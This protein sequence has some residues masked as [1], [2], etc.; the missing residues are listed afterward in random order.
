MD[1]IEKQF[2]SSWNGSLLWRRFIGF[3]S[4]IYCKLFSHLLDLDEEHGILVAESGITLNQLLE[5]LIPRGWFLPVTPGTSYVTLGG[6]VAADVH[7]KNH[8]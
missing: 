1:S 6:A 3:A 5:T 2:Y 8:H 4:S 7:G